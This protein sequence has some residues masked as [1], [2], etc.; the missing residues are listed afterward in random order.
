[1]RYAQILVA[2]SVAGTTA[3]LACSDSENPS[4]PNKAT[5]AVAAA[6]IDCIGVDPQLDNTVYSENRVF[7][8]AQGWWGEPRADGSIP[9]FGDAEHIHVGMCFPLQTTVSG[10]LPFRVIV[11]GHNLRVNSIIKS[12]NLHD[13]DGGTFVK[14]FWDDTIKVAPGNLTMQ[15]AV[16]VN[17]ARNNQGAVVPS[18][19]REFRVLTIVKRPDGA[20]IHASSGWCW[21]TANGGVT[22][23]SG[24]C[25][26]S[27]LTT[28]GRGWYDCFEYKIAEVRN[29][30]YP[31]DG[32]PA[33]ANYQLSIGARDGAGDLGNM[34]LNSWTVR[35]NPNFHAIPAIPGTILGSGTQPAYGVN[36]SIPPKLSGTT[37]K[38]VVVASANG[39]CSSSGI[40]TQRG[41]VSAVQVIPIKVR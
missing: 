40:P 31:Y 19:R 35:L 13:P 30:A 38:L 34:L 39:T 27:P 16:S 4:S 37:Q 12:T 18:G 36:V 20:E 10:V 22:V 15:R 32:I 9:R 41:E 1:V 33:N 17:T 25:K 29:W 6:A 14:I 28:M 24:T 26:D 2:A 11:L 7:L 23:N 3:V 5:P 8:E 21:T